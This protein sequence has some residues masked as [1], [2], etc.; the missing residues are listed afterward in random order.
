[1]TADTGD[2]V[3]EDRSDNGDGGCCL[4]LVRRGNDECK[5]RGDIKDDISSAGDWLIDKREKEKG[6]KN[7]NFIKP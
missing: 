1:M 6:P 5:S 2:R 3:E 7:K 4:L